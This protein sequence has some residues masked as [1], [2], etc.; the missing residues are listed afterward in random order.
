MSMQK[1][2]FYLCHLFLVIHAPSLMARS[3][4]EAMQLAQAFVQSDAYATKQVSHGLDAE[5]EWVYTHYTKDAQSPAVY[6]FNIKGSHGSILVSADNKAKSILAY[7]REGR[8]DARDIPEN[9]RF[10]L[11]MYAH[12]I[13]YMQTTP[14]VTLVR[15][16][17]T[18]YT[19][20][21]P[22]LDSINW[23]QR[24][25]FNRLCP[26]VNGESTL[27]GCVA[28]ALSQ[29]MYYYRHPER[30]RGSHSYIS[31][32]HKIALEADFEDVVFDWDAMLADYHA[33]YTDVQ[34]DAVAQLLYYIGVAVDMDY[35][36]AYSAAYS[37]DGV[38]ALHDYFDYDKSV[39]VL[40]K[41]WLTETDMLRY[42]AEDLQAGHPILMRGSSETSGHAFLCD[43]IDER[44]YL[45]INWG[46]TGR[47]EGY[48]ALSALD[49]ESQDGHVS[50]GEYAYTND[51]TA[52][53][54]IRPNEG[55]EAI[56]YLTADS[57][58]RTTDDPFYLGSPLTIKMVNFSN[59]GLYTTTGMVVCRI[60][61]ANGLLLH[62]IDN[63]SYTNNVFELKEG[64][65]YGE[66][67]LRFK[68]TGLAL[69]DGNYILEIAAIDADGNYIPIVSKGKSNQQ[70]PIYVEGGRIVFETW[71]NP[72]TSFEYMQIDEPKNKKVIHRGQLFIQRGGK[73][74]NTMGQEV[75]HQ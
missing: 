67:K 21:Q 38:V 36:T 40:H 64:Y 24:Q 51:V 71:K 10:W 57:L 50:S 47:Y 32:T 42:M 61:D 12:E 44:G 19:A 58:L 4:Q 54:G 68:T 43:G 41:D 7:T 62:S 1:R 20:I 22:L 73:M 46:W 2:I 15:R 33:G 26:L 34:A 5:L 53:V 74:Y 25:P 17:D 8:F 59:K 28:T 6:V 9:L 16:Q 14:E 3:P 35:S 49:Y 18:N 30:G 29:I 52:Y 65:Y 37:I 60:Y 66:Y 39:R 70:M 31:K 11:D 63:S 48:F 69:A 23:G 72:N 75:S 27:T 13:A 45:H 55:G 56:P